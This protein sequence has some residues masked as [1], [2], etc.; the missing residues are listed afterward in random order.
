LYDYGFLKALVWAGC[1]LCILGMVLLSISTQ[2]WQLLLT[3]G[4]LIGVG[5]GL[6]LTP[7]IAILPPYFS[8]RRALALGI[9]DAG[10]PIGLYGLGKTMVRYINFTIGGIVF[11]IFFHY[12]QPK[13]G[14]GWTTRSIALIMLVSSII[15]IVGIRERNRPATVVARKA[16]DTKAWMEVPFLLFC[17]FVFLIFMGL[18]IPSF[19]I[20]SYGRRSIQGT[21]GNYLLPMMNLASVIGRIVCLS[22]HILIVLNLLI[23]VL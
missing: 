17:L 2:Y 11:P 16:F 12:L 8:K 4:V 23:I 19:Y 20:Q 22:F 18:Y 6:L 15:P 14:F 5:S 7:C 3:Q 1:S 13:I 9:S 21:L 10:S